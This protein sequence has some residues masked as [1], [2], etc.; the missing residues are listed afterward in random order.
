MNLSKKQKQTYRHRQ[1]TCG[2]QGVGEEGMREM[3][4]EF[5]FSR[6]KVL[7]LEWISNEILLYRTGNCVQI[8]VME[9]DE[10]YYE[11]KKV[12]INVCVCVC[13]C[14]CITGLLWYT[15]K[16]DRTL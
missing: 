16:T 12:Q 14:V 15:A 3:D 5:G 1:Q 6:C 11:K 2:C 8:L 13:V 7:H 10:R 9:H 4:W